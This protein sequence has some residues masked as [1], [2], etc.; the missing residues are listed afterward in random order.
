MHKIDKNG[1][2]LLIPTP[3]LIKA[4]EKIAARC[5]EGHDN[6]NYEIMNTVVSILT[7]YPVSAIQARETITLERLVAK[8][9]TESAD[10]KEQLFSFVSTCNGCKYQKGKHC[11]IE[12]G[13]HCYRKAEDCYTPEVKS[14]DISTK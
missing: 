5:K 10:W 1:M 4:C 13:N 12:P 8:A 14:Q 3:A 9:L 7:K 6:Y 2:E 11:V